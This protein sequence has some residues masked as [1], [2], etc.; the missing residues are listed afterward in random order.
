MIGL[1]KAVR[2]DGP[3]LVAWRN[4]DL[5]A[6][7]DTTPLTLLSHAVWW[8]WTYELDPWDH[9]Y[10]VE[11]GGKPAGTIGVKLGG[12]PEIHRVLLGDKTLARTK[13]MSTA[14]ELLTTGYGF[15]RYWLLVKPGNEPAIRFYERNGFKATGSE[16]DFL[17][18]ER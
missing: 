7:G 16:D 2:E 4:A 17:V 11:T 9:L 12:R 10:I 15:P 18:M 8:D 3:L 6:F 13:V 1:R 5:K 14:L